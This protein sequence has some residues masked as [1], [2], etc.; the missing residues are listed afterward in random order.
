MKR[1]GTPKILGIDVGL[2][3][4]WF[5]TVEGRKVTEFGVLGDYPRVQFA[6]I[7]APLSFP[8]KGSF[9]ECEKILL[10]RGIPLFPPR[11]SFFVKIG[12]KGQKIAEELRKKGVE[13]YEVYPFATRKIIGIAPK[14]KKGRKEG[15]K[16]IEKEL[17]DYLDFERFDNPH[18]VDAAICALTVLLNLEGRAEVISGEDGEILIPL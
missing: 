10:M 9:R 13:V 16:M 11:A 7:D 14:V 17:R 5:V 2:R 6:G 4:S 3:T 8:M 15:W 12:E 1:S 18:L